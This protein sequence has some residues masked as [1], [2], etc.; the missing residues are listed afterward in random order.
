MTSAE[1]A[2]DA[3]MEWRPLAG[4]E[5]ARQALAEV[6]EGMDLISADPGYPPPYVVDQERT[7][8]ALGVEGSVLGGE[9]LISS[10]RTLEGIRKFA[11]HVRRDADRWP[12]LA[13]RLSAAPSER[14]L[15][16]RILDVFDSE[17][18][19][20]DE[21]SPDLKRR[22]SEVR[23]Q[24]SRLVEVLE[25]LLDRLPH[26]LVAS[27]SR[28]TVR[29]GRYVVPLR[30]E[31]LGEVPGIVHD[32]SASGATV[33]LEPR[34]VVERNNALRGAEL[35]ARREEERILRELTAA[36]AERRGELEH[37]ARLALHAETV[38]ARS[39][40]ALETN[41]SPPDIG[42]D[43]LEIAGARHPLLLARARAE[44]PGEVVP[45][46]LTLEPGE[47]VL[48]VSGPNT[49]GKTVLLKTIGCL[50]LMAQS[51]IVP[52]S[53]AGT[54]LP[55]QDR[56][57]A[58]IGDAQSI[59]QDLSSFTAHLS[60]LRAAWE[61]AGPE[62][63][64]LVDEIGG[65][66]DPA[67]GAA[68]A[69]ALL[70]AWV[71]RGVRTVVTTHFHAL[72]ALAAATPGM[73]NG[74]LAYDI[75]KNLP[76]YRFLQ[77]VPGRSFGLDLAETWGFEE[78]VERAREHLE[79]GVR[80]LDRVIDGLVAEERAH[81]EARRA[82]EREK[83]AIGEAESARAREMAREASERREAAERRLGELE[84]QLSGLRAELRRHRRKLEQRTAE[85]AEAEAA[86]EA[87]RALA[88]EAESAAE[89]LRSEREA[90][91]KVRGEKEAPILRVGDRVRIPRYDL[92]GEVVEV[93]RQEAAA[94]VRAGQVRIACEASECELVEPTEE[95]PSAPATAATRPEAGEAAEADGGLPYEVDLRGMRAAEVG[96]PVAGAL[97][98]AYHTGRSRIR[99][100]HGK[101][102][103]V[104]R[105][106][107]AELL[108]NHP[109][110]RSFRVGRWNEGGNGVTI[111]SL[112]DGG[113]EEDG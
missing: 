52:P 85:L 10:A 41:G 17:A 38:L 70:E 69:S 27:D 55:W 14:D 95:E 75:E 30:R 108:E 99:F 80:D 87:S 65:S 7:V 49:G 50:V 90:L 44:E 83:K 57:W 25:A 31:A 43:T 107:V 24:R 6:A 15:E 48:V 20:L 111:V 37:A 94:T 71:E 54:R 73:V 53:G 60:R 74:S 36:L 64:V 91:R 47:R 18:R 96:F 46:E 26:V 13:E 29:E 67:E 1:P 102:S 4:P 105:R 84:E 19:L 104:L 12:R 113:E 86:A 23:T 98:S 51:G 97:E 112:E 61:G 89:A 103:G 22:R 81:R 2:R 11:R 63:L 59:A 62:S 58:D 21:A 5:A 45:L 82:L 76:R 100:I 28:P 40:Y 32:E 77:G 92:E 39:R 9:E 68:L 33:F 72:K 106:R 34:E 16:R 79:S 101:G 110:V 78:V 3:L 93:D 56:V 109:Y 88:Q 8:R 66:T 35:A 42:G